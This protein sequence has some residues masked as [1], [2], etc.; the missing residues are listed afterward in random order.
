M[1]LEV[2]GGV[3][4]QIKVATSAALLKVLSCLV[5]FFSSPP[6]NFTCVSGDFHGFNHSGKWMIHQLCSQLDCVAQSNQGVPSLY[7]RDCR[8]PQERLISA[9]LKCLAVLGQK[10]PSKRNEKWRSEQQY[11]PCDIKSAMWRIYQRVLVSM[12][13]AGKCLRIK[14]ETDR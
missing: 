7:T 6:C 11:R 13:A 9:G 14:C 12:P 10:T 5:Q 1:F 8:L 3:P 4:Y 2:V